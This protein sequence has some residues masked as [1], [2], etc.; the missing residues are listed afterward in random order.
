MAA[1]VAVMLF[2]TV[3]AGPAYAVLVDSGDWVAPIP[4]VDLGF[5]YQQHASRSRVYADGK[6]VLSNANLT[7]DITLLRYVHPVSVNGY[8][9]SPNVLLPLGTLRAGGNLAANGRTSGVGDLIFACPTWVVNN[10]QTRTFFG[11]LPFVFFPTGDYDKNRPLNLGENRWKGAF[12]VGGMHGLGKDF[13]LELTGDVTWYGKNTQ[14]GA[15]SAILKQNPLYMVHGY[16]NWHYSPAT[17]FALGAARTE[18]GTTSVNG[19]SMNDETR[20]LQG[21][22]VASTF[23]DQRTQLIFAAG[24]DLSVRNGLK[25]DGRLNFRFLRVLP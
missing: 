15:A 25:E 20:T 8:V 6:E 4:G 16:L 22:L 24:R 2:G 7:S 19:V 11:F 1:G 13:S 21:F 9:V 23:I 10:P 5:V 18:G 14:Y 3:G 17:T 12:Q